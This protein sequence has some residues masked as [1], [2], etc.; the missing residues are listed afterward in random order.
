MGSIQPQIR[1]IE[2]SIRSLYELVIA[3]QALIKLPLVGS[4]MQIS[5]EWDTL[6]QPLNEL[7]VSIKS[8]PRELLNEKQRFRYESLKS[9]A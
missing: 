7:V 9:T 6:L 5:R 3:K 8:F 1:S 4:G 2:Q